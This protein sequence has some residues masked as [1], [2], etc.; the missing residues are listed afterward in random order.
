VTKLLACGAVFVA[1][2]LALI[3][4]QSGKAQY[5]ATVGQ[6]QQATTSWINKR[7]AFTHGGGRAL[8]ARCEKDD[9]TFFFCIA[10][11]QAP[12]GYTGT[13]DYYVTYNPNTDLAHWTATG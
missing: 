12:G 4:A 2:V 1:L 10:K 6:V 13:K 9:A 8:S 7:L 5:V 3:G 11:I